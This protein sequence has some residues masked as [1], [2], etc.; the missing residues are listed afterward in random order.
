MELADIKEA[1]VAGFVAVCGI[2]T[3]IFKNKKGSSLPEKKTE[4]DTIDGDHNQKN[5]QVGNSGT[6]ISGSGHSISIGS[7]DE[8]KKMNGP[9]ERTK[10]EVRDKCKILFID[11]QPYMMTKLLTRNGWKNV[12]LVKDVNRID[13]SDVRDADVILVDIVGVGESMGFTDQGLGLA[14]A[15][16]SEYGSEKKIIIYSQE[17]KGDRFH[18]ALGKADKCVKKSI[19]VYQLETLLFNLLGQ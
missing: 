19:S 13:D 16:K 8:Q 10:D 2:I 18:P 7:S 9:S 3:Y 5:D 4:G 17:D 1:A 11:D 14:E 15:L 12:K 6:I